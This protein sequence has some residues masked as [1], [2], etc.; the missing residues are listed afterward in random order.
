MNY[1]STDGTS[2]GNASQRNDDVVLRLYHASLGRPTAAMRTNYQQE[3]TNI[4]Q[5][6]NYKEFLTRLGCHYSPEQMTVLLRNA[7]RAACAKHYGGLRLMDLIGD[8]IVEKVP[9]DCHSTISWDDMLRTLPNE[10]ELRELRE[11][12][13]KVW[14]DRQKE[15][16]R[17]E[18][19]RQAHEKSSRGKEG[20]N[21][22]HERKKSQD[23]RTNSAAEKAK[24][25]PLWEKDWGRPRGASHASAVSTPPLA[26]TRNS[27]GGGASGG[28]STRSEI[29]TNWRKK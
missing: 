23:Q 28:A 15:L 24:E 22:E 8:P 7:V 10:S 27:G 21:K 3:F 20:A 12:K 11:T 4:V 17:Q 29:D 19:A 13:R 18:K 6:S 14:L 2:S 25:K 1:S 9:S 26:H 5:V 16:R